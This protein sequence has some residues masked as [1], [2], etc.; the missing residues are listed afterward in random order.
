[1][2]T[3]RRGVDAEG[4]M[5]LVMPSHVV[6]P[7]L[8]SRAAEAKRRPCV[9]RV[10]PADGRGSLLPRRE[11]R[12]V[13]P[14]RGGRGQRRIGHGA[15]RWAVEADGHRGGGAAEAHGL[16]QNQSYMRLPALCLPS[17]HGGVSELQRT[18]LSSSSSRALRCCSST[19]CQRARQGYIAVPSWAPSPVP[20]A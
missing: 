10:P 2:P 9:S 13:S 11:R 8:F 19:A 15:A 20:S 12:R 17:H 18:P 7:L 4:F 6:P 16:R 3:S 14:R 5:G 1:M